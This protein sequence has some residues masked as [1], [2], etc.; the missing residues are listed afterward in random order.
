MLHTCDSYKELNINFN[1]LKNFYFLICHVV[2]FMLYRNHQSKVI[3][4][5]YLQV[6]CNMRAYNIKI[7][8]LQALLN[9]S[10]FCML[11]CRIAWGITKF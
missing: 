9:Y 7:K 4:Q 10:L 5:C 6:Q 2:Y 1:I 11:F 3:L 8:F